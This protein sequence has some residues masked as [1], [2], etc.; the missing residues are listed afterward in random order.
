VNA[1]ARMTQKLSTA[2]VEVLCATHIVL[3]AAAAAARVQLY[4][5]CVTLVCVACWR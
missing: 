2:C 3:R 5:A 4:T 1:K